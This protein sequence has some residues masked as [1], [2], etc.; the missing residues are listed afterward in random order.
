[1]N[2]LVKVQPWLD[3]VACDCDHFKVLKS[4]SQRDANAARVVKP[5]SF[6]LSWKVVGSNLCAGYIL[7]LHKRLLVSSFLGN[8]RI[9]YACKMHKSRYGLCARGGWI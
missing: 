3:L 8:T 9:L 4:F 5:V 1:M 7:R 2:T 6:G